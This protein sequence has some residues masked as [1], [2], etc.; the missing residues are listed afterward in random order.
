MMDK[1]PSRVPVNAFP[2]NVWLGG[3]I[4]QSALETGTSHRHGHSFIQPVICPGDRRSKRNGFHLFSWHRALAGTATWPA[5]RLV[6]VDASG[7]ILPQSQSSHTPGIL[8]APGPSCFNV[9]WVRC[10]VV[11]ISHGFLGWRQ[12]CGEGLPFPAGALGAGASKG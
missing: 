12:N 6:L 2:V 4:D 9:C 11:R 10:K 8:Q 3:W 1:V 5:F 7:P